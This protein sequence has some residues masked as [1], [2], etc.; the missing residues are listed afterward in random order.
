MGDEGIGREDDA[1][2]VLLSGAKSRIVPMT[3][4]ERWA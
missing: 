1:F 3:N 4:D 2:I